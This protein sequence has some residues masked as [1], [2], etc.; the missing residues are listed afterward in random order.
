MFSRSKSF[1]ALQP[2]E[3]KKSADR[4][5]IVGMGVSFLRDPKQE[6]VPFGS[7]FTPSKKGTLN[8]NKLGGGGGGNMFMVVCLDINI[9][10][11]FPISYLSAGD[12]HRK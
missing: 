12:S 4:Q 1:R 5:A 7:L 9:F 2:L 3:A 8:K 6:G 10:A 11:P